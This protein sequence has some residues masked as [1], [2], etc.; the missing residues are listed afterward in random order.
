MSN[1]EEQMDQLVNKCTALD[2]NIDC[3]MTS[4]FIKINGTGDAQF[5]LFKLSNKKNNRA[6]RTISG[7]IGS[8]YFEITVLNP[9]VRVG[10][11]TKS[12]NLLSPVGGPY[13]WAY[14]S[15]KGY[16][17]HENIRNVYNERFDKFDVISV[18]KN[19][20]QLRFF[21]N[22]EDCGLAF[23]N[24]EENTEY[25]PCLSFHGKGAEVEINFGPC[26]SYLDGISRQ[27]SK[28]IQKLKLLKQKMVDNPE[29][30]LICD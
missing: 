17:Y 2:W 27:E 21:K 9:Q 11:C 30:F 16:K 19:N 29:Y 15:F 18:W 3:R 14:G 24:L 8:F 26:F 20:N 12:F 13:S 1:L 22:G 23:D 10:I 5:K 28:N 6:V 25:F 4:L 7:I